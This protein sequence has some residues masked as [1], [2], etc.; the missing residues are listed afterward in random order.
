MFVVNKTVDAG[1]AGLYANIADNVYKSC[2]TYIVQ[3]SDPSQFIFS[4]TTFEVKVKS[5]AHHVIKSN[6]LVF[7]N[8]NST[9]TQV[10]NNLSG[11]AKA[12]L[13]FFR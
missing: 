8:N 13:I 3:E 6:G 7:G 5:P 1:G 12:Y 11:T 9:G 10:I 4:Y 2:F